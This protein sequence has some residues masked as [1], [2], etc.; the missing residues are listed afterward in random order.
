MIVSERPKQV[1]AEDEYSEYKDDF[2]ST[3]KN[4]ESGFHVE[5]SDRLGRI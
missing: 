2:E 1:E 3:F 5:S 4:S